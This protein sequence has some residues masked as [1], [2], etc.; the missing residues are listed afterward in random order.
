MNTRELLDKRAHGITPPRDITSNGFMATP[1][2]DETVNSRIG[3][4]KAMG[5]RMPGD[6]T[7][8]TQL[9]SL[10]LPSRVEALEQRVEQ[11]ELTIRLMERLLH[12]VLTIPGDTHERTDA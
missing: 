11:L 7:L 8:G 4:A 12:P 10:S 9:A 5:P 3:Y 6:K 2:D 1:P